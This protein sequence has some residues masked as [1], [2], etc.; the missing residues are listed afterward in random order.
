MRRMIEML[1]A[2]EKNFY[3]SRHGERCPYCGSSP[4]GLVRGPIN[5]AKLDDGELWRNVF[6]ICCGNFW[7]ELY[8]LFDIDPEG[9]IRT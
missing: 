5:D 9:R 2:D 4:S 7:T 1:S 3:L 6:C 8:R